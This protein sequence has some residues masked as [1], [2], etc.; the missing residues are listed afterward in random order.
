LPANDTGGS[1]GEYTYV[2]IERVHFGSGSI[3][4]LRTELDRLGAKRP[5]LITGQSIAKKTDLVSRIEHSAGRKLAGVF[6]EVQ[7][8][9]PMGGITRAA[10]AARSANADSLI[11][12]GGGSPIDS[13]K[14]II[15]QI[16]RDFQLP[17]VPHI[18]VPTTLSAAEFSHIA[19]M[20][21][22]KLNRKSG[23]RD[24][25]MVPRFVFLDPELTIPTPGWLWASS[26]IRSLDHAVEAVYLPNHQPYVDTLSLEAIRLL[27]ENLKISTE[28]PANLKSR[29]SC[30]MAAWMSFAGVVSVGMGLSH[31]IG[32]VIG[33]TWNIPHGITSCLTLSEVM[34]MEAERNPERL[35]LIARAEGMNLDGVPLE[36]AATQAADG[37]S[38]LVRGLGLSKRLR[39]Y[40]IKKDDLQGI[41][42]E[43]GGHESADALH[44]L[45]RIW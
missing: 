22:E 29:L 19:G 36:T 10:S 32:R 11:S 2:P 44:I 25:R 35:A 21:D 14:I 16:S 5:F 24:L 1:N 23:F 26:G 27:F 20:T 38:E 13:T 17:A 33:A 7:Q 9:A 6:A 39:D 45:E 28:D 34:R 42:R 43:A 41:A 18:A 4:Q 15:K 12:L 3:G 37:V 30:Q 31:S 8:H 40:G